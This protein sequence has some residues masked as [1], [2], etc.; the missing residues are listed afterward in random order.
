MIELDNKQIEEQLGYQFK[1]QK[2]LNNALTHSSYINEHKKHY[3]LNNE[4]LE[5]LGDATLELIISEY[6]YKH[7]PELTE[8]TLTK[9]RAQIVCTDSLAE[10][11]AKLGISN[12]IIMGKGE[13]MSGG[14]TRKSILANTMEAII[15]AIY[16]DGGLNETK[17][18]IIS[19]LYT[20]IKNVEHGNIT[21]DYKSILQVKIQR[22]KNQDLE[23][24]LIK[25]EGPDHNKRFYVKVLINKET[26]STGVGKSKKEAEQEAAQKAI[27]YLDTTHKY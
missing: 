15:G 6:L 8:G 7:F 21:R 1:D 19:R 22:Q 18:F 9:M 4:R 20:I 2:L 3:K 24:Q 12:A 14:R 17:D 13:I 5:F 25:E 27:H 11:A 10:S 16:L 23:Y 26:I